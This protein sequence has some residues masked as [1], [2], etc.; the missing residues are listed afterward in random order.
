MAVTTILIMSA[1]FERLATALQSTPRWLPSGA[2]INAFF[3]FVGGISLEI[4]LL[5]AQYVLNPL[6]QMH[7]GYWPT[8]LLT[9]AISVPIA[10]VISKICSKIIRIL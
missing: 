7:L 4:Y 1:V 10:W 5:H 3:T 8:F 9:F 6:N 2:G